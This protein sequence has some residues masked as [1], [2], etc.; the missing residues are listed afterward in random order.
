M[1]YAPFLRSTENGTSSTEEA[2]ATKQKSRPQ[3][4]LSL[5]FVFDHTQTASMLIKEYP[6]T[7]KMVFSNAFPGPSNSGIATS[8]KAT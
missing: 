1:A 3:S 4:G 5:C 2:N 6:N 8:T 7:T